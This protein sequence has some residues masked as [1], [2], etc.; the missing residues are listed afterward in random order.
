MP[1]AIKVTWCEA[2]CPLS[3]LA[4]R[5]A[6]SSYSRRLSLRSLP[7]MNSSSTRGRMDPAG[8]EPASATWTECYVPITPRALGRVSVTGQ[9]IARL[10][11]TICCASSKLGM[12]PADSLTPSDLLSGIARAAT[13]KA[14]NPNK[15]EALRSFQAPT[16][17]PDSSRNKARSSTNLAH[18][19]GLWPQW[20]WPFVIVAS[21]GFLLGSVA[22]ATRSSKV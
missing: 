4:E 7:K 9:T 21:Y 19:Q 1:G 11:V 6:M 15:E 17:F 3:V 2:L 18:S 13:S 20:T 22:Q 10:S 5:T 8:F 12:F 14:S 16:T